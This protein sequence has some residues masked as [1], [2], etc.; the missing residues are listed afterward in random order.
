M[1]VRVWDK[2]QGRHYKSVVYAL[3]Q[4]GWFEHAVVR[5]PYTNCFELVRYLEGKGNAIRP[6]FEVI[7]PERNG[8]VDVG[9]EELRRAELMLEER[10]VEYL[11]GY[12]DV[13][14]N[15]D[16]VSG[17]LAEKAV[18]F[19]EAGVQLREPEDAKVWNYIETQ[20]D[21]DAFM[22]LFAG[23]H[24]ALL[25]RLVYDEDFPAYKLTAVF[26]NSVWYGVVELCFERVVVMRLRPTA[27]NYDNYIS[28]GTLVVKDESVFWADDHL[29]GEDLSY[30]GSYIKALSL[31]WRKIG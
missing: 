26:D 11:S 25:R 3:V 31:K 16:L 12:G 22:D 13:V 20:A 1:F 28:C 8:W 21:A 9:Q 2:A 15:L 18:D 17:L 19:D 30:D 27:E 14:G 4:H 6:N 10:A 24:D 5:N 7:Q 29:K 23:F